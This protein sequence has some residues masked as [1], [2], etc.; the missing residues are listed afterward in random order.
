MD[1]RFG[2]R[3]LVVCLLLLSLIALVLLAMFQFDRQWQRM[4][5]IDNQLKEH[6]R[7]LARIRGILERG[8][9]G[10]L[11]S[12]AATPTTAP[13]TDHDM[14]RDPF[15]RIRAAQKMPG[16]ALGDHYVGVFG[17]VPDRLT[18]LVSTDAYSSDVQNYVL[19]SLADRDPDTL[20]WRPVLSTGWRISPDGLRIEFDLRKGVTFSDGEPFTADDVVF[21]FD[22]IMNPQVE[23]PR[24]RSYYEKIQAVEK[25][26]DYRVVFIFKEPYFKAFEFAGGLSILPKHFYKKFSPTE[27]NQSTGLLMGTG[28]YRLPDP[29]SWR[30]EPGKPI[31]LVRN[32]RYWG[33]PGPFDKLVWRIIE[34]ESARL[35][36]FT[37]GD[38]DE[39]FATPEQYVTL[40]KNQ[41]L[42]DRTNH[43]EYQSPSAGFIFIAWN[44]QR[45]GKP[46]PFADPR[47]RR[48]MTLLTDRQRIIDE[49]F[50]GYGLIVTGPFNPLT[51]QSNPDVKP[52][53]FDPEAAKALLKEAGYE[54]RNGDG[55]IDAPDGQPFEVELTYPATSETYN[56]V[57]LFLKD[58]FAKAG[59]VL[60]PNP[61]EW[62]VLLQRMDQRQFSAISLA[63]TGQIESDPYQIYHSSQIAGTGDN[64][65]SYTNPKLDALL[66][67]A[68]STI[69]EPARMALW[70]QVHQILHEDQPYTFL[71]SRKSLMFFDGRL[72]NIQLTRNGLN[73]NLEWFVP[74]DERKWSPRK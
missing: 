42:L 55:V 30:P 46:T 19:E 9:P 28:P 36:T 31:E 57:V 69:D 37:N 12:S 71:I 16:Y 23:A 63:W 72:R 27:F 45:D 67:N 54:D 1:R 5:A 26:D 48:A 14:S 3:D 13:S 58:T 49:I 35:T 15:D 33:E 62:S 18:P 52:W 25:L 59:V 61:T 53:P 65:I 51:P 56:R 22:W 68:R 39:F 4:T 74:P 8:A 44:Q 11:P 40:L 41:P 60:K 64:V 10:S 73:P 38:I 32:D 70:H 17:A 66:E 2:F 20:A 21:S 24:L 7:D 47:V 29:T 43:Y 34:N 50:L 6:T